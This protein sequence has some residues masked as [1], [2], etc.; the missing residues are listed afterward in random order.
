[1]DEPS[2]LQPDER[3]KDFELAQS[4]LQYLAE[5]PMAQDTAEGI[6]SF[7]VMR[8]KVKEDIKAVSRVLQQLTKSG[9]LEQVKLGQNI[10]YRLKTED[11]EPGTTGDP[12]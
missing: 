5:H 8:Q 4:I 6:A 10:L 3:Q 9:Q 2:N 11:P 1:V 12:D 7:W